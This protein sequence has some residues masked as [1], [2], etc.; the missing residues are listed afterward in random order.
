MQVQFLFMRRSDIYYCV[1][2]HSGVCVVTISFDLIL[3]LKHLR[4]KSRYL[5]KIPYI[6]AKES[7]IS[8]K[9]FSISAKEPKKGTYTHMPKT[10][11]TNYFGMCTCVCI[12]FMLTQEQWPKKNTVILRL[13]IPPLPPPSS[14]VIRFVFL[15]LCVIILNLHMFVFTCIYICLYTYI[16]IRISYVC[17]CGIY[18]FVYYM[19]VRMWNELDLSIYIQICMSLF[20]VHICICIYIHIYTYMHKYM[21]ANIHI[22]MLCTH[23][24]IVCTFMSMCV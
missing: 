13:Q 17:M 8:A 12:P 3:Q 24:Y 10:M 6:S 2:P 1:R 23:I 15:H 9:E 19:C 4:T 7:S 22:F 18:I 14:N 21:R 16:C 5:C 20:Y 11:R